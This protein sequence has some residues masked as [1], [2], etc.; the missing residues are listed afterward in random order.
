MR[1]P[2]RK[3]EDTREEILLA[4][5]EQFRARGVSGCSIAH[6][7]HALS[8]SPANV[9]K[10]F[11]SKLALADAICDRQITRIMGRLE[12]GGAPAPPPERLALVVR[13]LME[14]HLQ[15]LRENPYMFEMIFV[16]REQSFTSAGRYKEKIEHLFVE[17]ISEG[18]AAGIYHCTDLQK[19][20]R[21]AATAFVGVLHPVFIVNMSENELSQ[22]RD[23]LVDLVNA[24]LQNPLAR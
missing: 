6:I 21:T 24:A 8:M 2:R 16:M 9:F 1:R 13:Q 12:D 17:V 4:A 14:T 7:A 19:C 11:H 3:A 20:A 22:R 15:N 23:E 5:E 18:V 10:H